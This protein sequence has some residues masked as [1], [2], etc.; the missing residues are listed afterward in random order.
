MDITGRRSD[1]IEKGMTGKVYSLSLPFFLNYAF[2]FVFFP[3][4]RFD[5]RRNYSGISMDREVMRDVSRESLQRDKDLRS[6]VRAARDRD[7]MQRFSNDRRRF[8]NEEPEWFSGLY[9]EIYGKKIL[10]LRI[11]GEGRG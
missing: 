10:S 1:L 8:E 5:I 2:Q 4:L 11:G 9:R 6:D 7:R 3:F